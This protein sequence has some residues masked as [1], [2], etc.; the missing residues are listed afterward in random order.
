[1]WRWRA[2]PRCGPASALSSVPWHAVA[3]GAEQSWDLPCSKV[4]QRLHKSLVEVGFLDLQVS[5][6]FLI[7]T[8]MFSHVRGH[9]S[10]PSHR[11]PRGVLFQAYVLHHLST[12]WRLRRTEDDTS[13][14][15][16]HETS[17]RPALPG[18]LIVFR[19]NQAYSRFWVTWTNW[20]SRVRFRWRHVSEILSD[21]ES[22]LL[23]RTVPE[24]GYNQ[25]SQRG[26]IHGG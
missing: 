20:M 3:Q 10:F 23:V 6:L 13:P 15:A 11:H 25:Q 17:P 2:L 8:L 7:R 9:P 22:T 14:W 16:A 26:A 1:M 4:L 12:N 5:G 21:V 24:R 19:S 18:F